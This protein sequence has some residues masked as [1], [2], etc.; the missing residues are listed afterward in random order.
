M[1]ELK[2]MND[3]ESQLRAWTPRR[4]S[5]KLKARVFAAR[6][7]AATAAAGDGARIA[8]PHH[9]ALLHWLAPAT[10]ALLWLCV[11][12]NQRFNSPFPSAA[13]AGPFVAAAMSN[14]SVAAWLPGS[15][16]C[17]HNTMG[18]ETFEWTNGSRAQ[19]NVTALPGRRAND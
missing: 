2:D 11:V 16:V 14:Q 15:F 17:D 12:V 8:L 19:S 3:L 4:P 9:Q 6:P 13:S 18:G 1:K 5:P 7:V 10:A